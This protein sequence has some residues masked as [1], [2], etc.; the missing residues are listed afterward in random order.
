[1]KQRMSGIPFLDLPLHAGNLSTDL[2]ELSS[3]KVWYSK[4]EANPNLADCQGSLPSTTNKRLK[5][6]LNTR[7]GW[8]QQ[9]ENSEKVVSTFL[10][11]SGNICTG[12]QKQQSQQQHMM[13]VTENVVNTPLC[14]VQE[15]ESQRWSC[16]DFGKENPNHQYRDDRLFERIQ[17]FFCRLPLLQPASRSLFNMQI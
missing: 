9:A 1:M 17:C 8:F 6:E 4:M 13:D 15:P 16:G 10:I 7:G 12:R 14:T 11:S 5:E 3:K 2:Q